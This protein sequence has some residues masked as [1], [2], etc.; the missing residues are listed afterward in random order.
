MTIFNSV[1]PLA[2]IFAMM[3]FT[4]SAHTETIA[5]KL[6]YEAD[7]KLLIVHADDIGMCHAVNDA[8]IKAFKKGMVTS[9]SI[10]VPCPWFPEIAA[11]CKKHPEVDVGLHLT[12][13][14]EWKYYR[15]RPVAPIAQV[16]G[17]VDEEGFMW[18][19]VKDVVKHATPEEVEIELRAQIERAK[20]F[21]IH[22][23]H[24]DTHMGTLFASP[25]FFE[26]YY[27]LGEEYHVPPMM[28]NPTPHVLALFKSQGDSLPDSVIE[29]IRNS[30]FPMLDMLITRVNGDAYKN[31]KESYYRVLKNLRPGVNQIIIHLGSNQSELR[32]ITGVWRRRYN[33]YRI[34]TSPETKELLDELNI[35]LIGWRELKE[36]KSK[37]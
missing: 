12:L 1:Y 33:D 29:L 3:A 8:S 25:K 18:R 30:D 31:R 27:K 32:H 6:G 10:M 34:F 28:I 17:L 16:P 20:K 2:G 13:T 37:E 14:S 23:T 35:K 4:V 36:V 22:P 15:W 26:V 19:K 21:G 11:Y 24:L 5:E 7:A 9:G